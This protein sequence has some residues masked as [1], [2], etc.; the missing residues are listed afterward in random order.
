MV[1][2]DA[3]LRSDMDFLDELTDL[4]QLTLDA[5]VAQVSFVTDQSQMFLGARGLDEPLDSTRETPL[6]HSFCQH[7]VTSA[8]P[9][10][11]ADAPNNSQVCDN[12]AIRDMGVKAY[13]G[14][15]IVDPDGQILGSLCAI[16]NQ[17]RNWSARDLGVLKGFAKAITAELASRSTYQS[18]LQLGQKYESQATN[19]LDVLETSRVGLWSWTR[20]AGQS[21]WPPSTCQLLGFP[22]DDY[23]RTL[24]AFYEYLTEADQEFLLNESTRQLAIGDIYDV[25]IQVAAPLNRR[26]KWIRT[27]G[28]VIRDASGEIERIH[29][30]M[31]DIDMI[32]RT[33]REAK[34][35]ASRLE[36]I[37][38]HAPVMIAEFNA[39]LQYMFANQAYVRM[40]GNTDEE[41]VG[42]S[43][44]EVLGD[45][46]FAETESRMKE[47]L[48]GI[49]VEYE[50]VLGDRDAEPKYL[51]V[52]Y[53]PEVNA[54]GRVTSV[55]AAIVDIT[56][57]TTLKSRAERL[58]RL[59]TTA[60]NLSPAGFMIFRAVRDEAKRITD[61]I[62]EYCNEAG[63]RIASRDREE[64][65][66]STLLATL[67]GNKE[68]GLFDGYVSVVET[69]EPFEATTHYV[70]DGLDFWVEVTAIRLGDGFAVSFSDVSARKSAEFALAENA[71]RLQRILDNVVA[72]VGVLSADGVLKEANRPALQAAGI[73][74][75]AA[76]GKPFWETYW[77]NFDP[78]V[79]DRLRKA[80]ELAA[81]GESSRYDT[82]IRVAHDQHRWIDFQLI[83][84]VKAD[85]SIDE[86]IPSGVDITERKESER[87]RNLLV[88]ELNH[89]VKNSL[90]TIQ[91]MAR[92]TIRTTSG[93]EEFE[94]TF[95]ARLG[96]IAAAHEL[97]MHENQGRASLKTMIERQIG[98]Y[99]NDLGRQV[100]L[101]GQDVMLSGPSAHAIG[102]ILHELATNAAKY[103][104]LSV[105]N[106]CIDISWT[107]A[108][109]GFVSMVWKEKDGPA[110][111]PPTRVGFGSRLIKQSLEY[112]L[113][114][115]AE[116]D[117]AP[118]G[119]TV[120]LQF[121][122][123]ARDD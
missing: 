66:G 94:T 98:P 41:V 116:F 24:E 92:Q 101:S 31:T 53:A 21:H 60:H 45:A 106:A 99:T 57:E 38:H 109:D 100:R 23:P 30:Q 87:H 11:V 104:G 62:F 81:E 83:P 117:Y 9:L 44:R 71:E 16:D 56:T 86:I 46:V 6:T 13:I 119:L 82:M 34:R 80:I 3:L 112:S 70:H 64:L 51:K 19:I 54:Q 95:T 110:V 111:R 42:R 49:I 14:T 36:R 29:G 17:I 59:L 79:Q 5:P 123:E 25:E 118:E 74:R 27:R 47:A 85:G 55:I 114:G 32:Y 84:L 120:E 43:A 115:K 89:R 63:S 50:L 58:D 52:R 88:G 90:A 68:A 78:G 67:P 77:W 102:L 15:P 61:F 75:E 97:L 65:I 4:I 39:E 96:A 12:L 37:T 22:E 8:A 26:P 107:G 28:R 91:A 18:Y 113:G 121:P 73:N 10:I 103:G 35:L 2:A 7:V 40:F 1:Q 33:D 72:F 48:K 20:E 108:P 69:G 105:E 93:L 76:I 122:T